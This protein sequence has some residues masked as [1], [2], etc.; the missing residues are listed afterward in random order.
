MPCRLNA[1]LPLGL[2]VVRLACANRSDRIARAVR[3]VD[4]CGPSGG[5]L[6]SR[7]RLTVLW[8]T[9]S[10]F[11]AWHR[12][13]PPLTSSRACASSSASRSLSWSIAVPVSAL[14]QNDLRQRCAATSPGSA[15]GRYDFRSE[16]LPPL[17]LRFGSTCS[18]A[19]PS[20]QQTYS[21]C[22]TDLGRGFRKRRRRRSLAGMSIATIFEQLRRRDTW[23]EP[24]TR[25][26][27]P[28]S[29]AD[30]RPP[31]HPLEPAVLEPWRPPAPR[32]VDEGSCQVAGGSHLVGEGCRRVT[33]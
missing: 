25:A 2:D 31:R 26:L 16:I 9:P 32:E 19:L 22:A 30:L 12:L 15:A 6:W 8:P 3:R 14:R 1:R 5:P 23:P 20:R 27:V 28:A 13:I 18:S 24:P 17:P 7:S 11:A 10:A 33:L 21:A 29:A 4:R